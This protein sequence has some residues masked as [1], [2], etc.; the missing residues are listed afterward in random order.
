[1]LRALALNFNILR[2]LR[3]F[4]V[5][6]KAYENRLPI[7]QFMLEYYIRSILL[8]YLQF[9]IY[10]SQVN[11]IVHDHGGKVLQR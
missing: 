6:A 7:I 11:E 3:F 5:L 10:T 4:I 1:M 9:G 2:V 8:K